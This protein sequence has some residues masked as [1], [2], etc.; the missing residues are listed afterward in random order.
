M[1]A[2]RLCSGTAIAQQQ[3]PFDPQASAQRTYDT[4]PQR[5]DRVKPGT[6][7][8]LQP[9][10]GWSHLVIA[11]HPHPSDEARRSVNAQTAELAGMIVTT[12]VANVQRNQAQQFYLD[13]VAMGLGVAIKGKYSVVSPDTQ[14]K[15]GANLGLFARIVLSRFDDKQALCTVVARSETLAIIDTPAV[16]I[17]RGKHESVV[18][19]YAVLVNPKSGRLETVVWEIDLDRNRYVASEL[20][21]QWLPPN[22]FDDV[23]LAVDLNEFTLGIPSEIAFATPQLPQGRDLK[24]S[25]GFR[26]L[27]AV[28]Q[29]TAEHAKAIEAGLWH[30]ILTL[31]ATQK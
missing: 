8:T 16:M 21:P 5:I 13:A 31:S 27:A 12:F 20:T 18:F 1:L 2:L 14:E 17:R 24:F 23:N 11:A 30:L 4:Q 6:P 29:M 26:E 22:K 19:R 10:E 9:P 15:L 3:F 7:I 28:Q 25:D